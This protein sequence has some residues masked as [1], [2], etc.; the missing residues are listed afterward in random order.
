MTPESEGPAEVLGGVY[1]AN[2]T[3]FR[4]DDRYGKGV[5]LGT[6][7]DLPGRLRTAQWAISALSNIV[8]EQVVALYDHVRAGRTDEA[9]AFDAAAALAR[10]VPVP[11]GEAR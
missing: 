8:P 5:L 9:A 3:P 6:E 2:V 1:V 4:A 11:A 10:T 7:D